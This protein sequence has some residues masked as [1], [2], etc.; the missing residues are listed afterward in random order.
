M[1]WRN[2]QSKC[3]LLCQYTQIFL[4]DS[5]PHNKFRADG[6]N[7]LCGWGL[8]RFSIDKEFSWLARVIDFDWIVPEFQT[9]VCTFLGNYSGTRAVCHN[10]SATCLRRAVRLADAWRA[11][12]TMPRARKEKQHHK[13]RQ[14]TTLSLM[15]FLME[16]INTLFYVE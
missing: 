12:L 14:K 16:V 13:R 5:E 11:P 7:I 2:N 15:Y 4:L 8:S 10:Q 9:D 6:H 3:F 1:S